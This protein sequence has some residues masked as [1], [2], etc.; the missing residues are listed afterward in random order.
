[1]LLMS[2]WASGLQLRRGFC[3]T[4]TGDDLRLRLTTG[5]RSPTSAGHLGQGR[6][7]SLVAVLLHR[8]S[9]G[10]YPHNGVVT[11]EDKEIS[12]Y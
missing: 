2:S 12:S 8:G 5:L 6:Q 10:A 4:Q 9:S 7:C 11:W 1:M 3:A